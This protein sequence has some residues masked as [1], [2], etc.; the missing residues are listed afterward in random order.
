VSR[1]RITL[2]L[3]LLLAVSAPSLAA[4]L[5]GEAEALQECRRYPPGKHF[6]WELRGQV[7]LQELL[8]AMAPMLCRPIIVSANIRPPKVTIL[9]PES[10]TA[11][12]AY[13][14]FLAALETM[15]LTV[16]PE[17]KVLKVIESRWARQ[18]PIPTYTG[19]A[20]VQDEFVTRLMRLE[21]VA[22]DD[23]KPVLERLRGRDGDVTTYAPTN[24]LVLTDLA[25][26]VRRMEEVAHQ[27]DV[28]L[29]G[30]RIFLIQLQHVAAS[31]MATTLQTIFNVKNAP[32]L[33]RS[34]RPSATGTPLATL[35][36]DLAVSQVIPNEQQNLIVVVSSESAYR[37]MLALVERLDHE[38]ATDAGAGLVH[39]MPLENADADSVAGTL[40]GIGVPVSRS[41][42]SAATARRGFQPRGAAQP[43]APFEGE[44]HVVA[45][46]PTNSLIVLAAEHDFIT[47]R[48]LIRKLD[49][50]RRQVFV[51]ADILEVTVDKSRSLGVAWHGGSTIDTGGQ[52]SLL[53]GG[54]EPSSAVNSILFSPAALSGLAAGL[55][56]PPIPG[57]DTIL[58]LPP[59]TS[60]PS[61][62]VFLQL[63]QNNGDVNVVSMPHILTTDNEKATIQVGQNLP[64][65]G[66]L[67]GFPGFGGGT[68]G[69]PGSTFGFGTSVQ[70]QDVALKLEITPHVNDSDYVRLELNNELSDVANPNYNGL[71]PATSKRTVKSVVTV[72][73][74]QSIVLGGLIKDGVSSTV[75][76][77]P[78]LG[79]IPII[80]YLF[81]STKKTATKQN[82][83]IILTPYIIKDPTDLRRVFERKLR[84]RR[85]FL[86]RYSAFRDDHD[87]E[88]DIDYRHQ[89]GLLEEINRT[90]IEAAQEA[91]DLQAAQH[92]LAHTLDGPVEPTPA[93][94]RKG[95]D[96]GG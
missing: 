71:G 47:L 84:E 81:K 4:P 32:S 65:P 18:E 26:N 87:Y 46:K 85:E 75:Q 59:G 92:Q 73:D 52:Q 17:G 31:E 95:R 55:R 34:G 16:E 30:E 94:T 77:V 37:R 1:A 60:I 96:A 64:F 56:G 22:P 21:N 19:Q 63:L 2:V 41:G 89:P 15:S 93:P 33:R 11:P 51:E 24:T 57:A 43:T 68:T 9:A 6:K 20:P 61:F 13:R 72:K 42:A 50:P 78:L 10:I 39:V 25:T 91:A 7:D 5:P 3:P 29:G 53:F 79:D 40:A 74:Q 35:G 80:G 38:G 66:A 82:L 83:L 48:D 28:P 67:G 90:A 69:L 54:S 62:G 8:G 12:E 44:V 70:R 58:G 49:I 45:D 88:P 23:V 14:M 27:L 76:K 36:P 86:E